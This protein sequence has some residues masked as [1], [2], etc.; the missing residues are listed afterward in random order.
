MAIKFLNTVAVDTDVLYVDASSNNV[1]IGTTSPDSLL[2]ISTTDPTKNFIKLTS[3]AGSVNPTLI[4]EKSAVEQGVIQYIRNGDLKIYNTDSDG[5]VMLSGSSATNYDMY[6]NNSGN[7]GIGTTS[8]GGIF[9]VFQQST[10]RTR[11]DLLVDAG[12][13]YV[14]VG[15]LSTTSGD[16]SSFKVRDRLNRAYLDVNTYSKYISFNPEIGDITMQIASGYGFKVNGGQ[17]NVNASTGNVGIG[18]TTPQQKL[19]VVG[20]VRASYNTSNYYEIGASSAGGFVVGKSG[21]V[22]TVNIRTY[23]DSHFN[24]GNVG[25]GT[26]SPGAKLDVAGDI[27]LNSIGQELQFSNHSVGAY[28]DGSNRLMIS[29]YGGIRFQAEAVGGMENQATRMVINPSGNVGIGTTSPGSTIP[30]DAQADP[31]T[32]EINGD[33]TDAVLSL[34]HNIERG[35]DIWSDRNAANLIIDSRY[36]SGNVI[37]GEIRFRTRTSE[38]IGSAINAMTIKQ[39]GNVGI[40]TTSPTYKL[41]VE[42]NA[43]VDSTLSV[44]NTSTSNSY[45]YLLSSSTG[46]SELRMGDSDT[47]AGSIAYNNASDFMAFRANAAERMRITSGGNVGIGTTNPS[48]KLEVAGNARITGDVTL[49]NGNALRWTSDDVRIEGTTAG[50]NIK[51]YVANTEILQLAQS[52]TLATVTGNLRVTGAYYD[53][54]NLPGTSGQVLSSTAT[55]TDWVSLS[56]ISG[57]DGTGTANTVAMW[58]D[59]DTITDAPI[60]ISGSD[61]TFAGALAVTNQLTFPYGFLGDY[62]YHTGDTNTYFGFSGNDTF[63]LITGGSSRL[64]VNSSGNVGIGTTSPSAKLQISTTMTSSPTSNIFLDVDGSNTTGGGGS[65]IFGTSATAGSTTSYNAKITG[66]RVAGGLGG[67]SELGF[68]TT[69]VSDTTTAQQRMTIT[70]EGNVGIGTTSPDYNLDVNG[71]VGINGYIYHNGDDSRIGFEGNDAIRMYTANSVRLQINSTG[72]V[73]IGT[74][75]PSEKLHVNGNGLFNGG[76]TVG[77][78]AADTFITRGHTYLATTGNNVGIG[79]TSPQSKLQVAGGVQM[80]DDTDAASADKVGTLRYRTSGNNSY[81][82]MCMQ[83]GAT[84][85]EWVNIVQNNW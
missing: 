44:A 62:I 2:E 37:G 16:V 47:D 25:I 63:S 54:N 19:D 18:T 60:T 73:G 70:K 15:R 77:D 17:F 11:G 39:D 67:D 38:T 7:V 79:T 27:R 13:K 8:P 41:Q 80:A 66:T 30:L 81:V 23:G 53:S 26:T 34:R 5:G 74:T 85:Y 20:R 29:G 65:I 36:D 28:R 46:E 3:G 83:T 78:S 6:I 31:K 43:Y 12:A 21:G 9:E 10:G 58:S 76:L 61:S 50:D 71:D 33:A 49:S 69:L 84:T 4:F 42:G 68:W 14:Y 24:G 82:D 32:L 75:S 48:E 22:E 56:E 57:V 59:S 64:H 35:G 45:I 51:F 40:G 55:G 52:G 72:N 1:G